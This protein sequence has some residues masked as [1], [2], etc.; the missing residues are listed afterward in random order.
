MKGSSRYGLP[1]VMHRT[2]HGT[3]LGRRDSHDQPQNLR[4]WVDLELLLTDAFFMYG[5]HV[6]TG[7]INPRD[8]KEAWFGER[9]LV[10]L[11]TVLQ[12][13]SETDRVAEL[14]QHLATD[15]CRLCCLAKH[16]GLV[17]RH[18]STGRLASHPGWAEAAERGS[19][20]TCGGVKES[21]TADLG[22]GSSLRRSLTMS[23]TLHSNTACKDSRKGTDSTRTARSE[24]RH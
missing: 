7:Q 11:G 22:S 1:S 21:T 23:S 20:S 24:P 8:L 19:R 9:S 13:A 15:A 14:L 18:C 12:Q 2:A 5:S 4:T 17:S 3:A 16:L 6:L 10:D